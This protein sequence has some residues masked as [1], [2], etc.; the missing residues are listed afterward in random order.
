MVCGLEGRA[1]ILCI[2][3]ALLK[4]YN[5]VHAIDF[6]GHGASRTSSDADLSIDTLVQD[7]VAVIGHIIPEPSAESSEAEKPQTVIVGH[8]YEQYSSV[9]INPSIDVYLTM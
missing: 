9:F 6:R 4:V 3:Q 7:M 5:V 2:L 1:D 8:R